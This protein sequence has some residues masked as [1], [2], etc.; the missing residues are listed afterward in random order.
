MRK[1]KVLCFFALILSFTNVF[2]GDRAEVWSRM[3]KRSVS[4]ELKFSVMLNIVE[5]NDR[6]MIPLLEEILSEDIIA[7][8]NN[9]RGVTDEQDFIELTKL[10]VKELGELKSKSSAPLVYTIVKET[11]DP[12]LKADAII[13][14]GN[15]RADKY[16]DDISFILKSN[17]SRPIKGSNSDIEAEAKVSY[18]CIA[19]LDRFRNIEGYSSVFF[20]SVGWYNQRVRYFADKVLKTIVENPIEALIPILV[21]GS[22][23]DKE[24]AINEVSLCKAPSLDKIRA[25]REGLRQ[26]LDNVPG[27]IQEGMTLTTIRKNSIKVL[28]SSKSS[29][30]E[31]VYFL[32]Q[33][34]T[35]GADL[36]EKIYGIRT[37]GLN[38]SDEAIESLSKVLDEFN[39]R[40]IDG[41]GVTYAEEDVV[42]EIITTLG[43]SGNSLAKAILTEVQ[44]SGY[45]NG[46][47][48]RAKEALKKLN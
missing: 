26:G 21:E 1:I 42:R 9:K 29:S 2:A 23:A 7:N 24:K 45:P 39:Q 27:S 43:N 14:L 33:S 18:G 37:L 47:V 48:K 15:M 20:A 5:L 25:A 22:F 40:N 46:I 35:K 34:V 36:E 17:N 16:I 28:Y 6:G 30:V 4:S 31:D 38:G 11:A 10:V 44:F 19:A 12:L 3:Y 13:A 8:L 32:T 41:I